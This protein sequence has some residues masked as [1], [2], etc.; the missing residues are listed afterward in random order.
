MKLPDVSTTDRC[1][2]AGRWVGGAILAAIAARLVYGPAFPGYD[3]AWSLV[4]GHDLAAGRLPAFEAPI[5]PTP[6]PLSNGVAAM[7]AQTGVEASIDLL[8]AV[9]WLAFGVLGAATFSVGRA[10]GG[11]LVG[12]VAAA[13]VLTRPLV[14]AEALSVSLDIPFLALVMV[15]L[16]FAVRRGPT[17][18]APLLALLP[19]GL[20]RPE[21]WLLALAWACIAG[22][23][24][25]ARQR[26]RI[27]ALA[28]AAPL[29]WALSDLLVT[30]EPLFSFT[31]TREL[32]DTL[33][34]PQ[35]I[36]R[37]GALAGA[38]TRDILGG[39]LFVAGI[40]G[41]IA[42][43]FVRQFAARLVA[44][45]VAIGVAAFLLYGLAGLP[46]LAR[47][48]LIPTSALTLLG[49]WVL[50]GWVRP[51]P[52]AE[53]PDRRRL[54]W[55]AAGAVLGVLIIAGAGDTRDRVSRHKDSLALRARTY[56]LLRD[57]ITSDAVT[58]DLRGC[59]VLLV[60]N[61]R[62]VP[63]A[64]LWSGRTV[65]DA[66]GAQKPTVPARGL[67][68]VPT[69][70]SVASLTI[71]DPRDSDPTPTEPPAGW[72]FRGGNAGWAWHRRC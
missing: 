40:A 24:A 22:W 10:L 72:A 17:S 5:A 7:L 68:I 63:L 32:A 66:V 35:T 64:A 3:A 70:S 49:A 19:A 34:R 46:V 38:A 39:A 65:P 50:L 42:S 33:G 20:L 13:L 45:L 62:A 29:I 43:L 44:A 71:L 31:G 4:W 30:G 47:Y 9:G 37:A 6:H 25:P 55:A 27:A 48:T 51:V 61:H 2:T 12:I 41:L 8:A 18:I 36:R 59:P 56:A 69:T 58:A 21:A 67:A 52:D 16:A 11:P 60:P 26:L 23:K 14:V 57:L 28:L 1:L 54:A 53:R 15:A